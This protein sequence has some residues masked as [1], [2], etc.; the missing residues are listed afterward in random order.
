MLDYFSIKYL[1]LISN[2]YHKKKLGLFLRG[3]FGKR[4]VCFFHLILNIIFFELN[5]E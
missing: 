4:C 2:P 5:I 1:L 3:F